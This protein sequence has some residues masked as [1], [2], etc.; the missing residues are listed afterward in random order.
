M[1]ENPITRTATKIIKSTLH[2]ERTSGVPRSVLSRTVDITRTYKY[3]SIERVVHVHNNQPYTHT[4]ILTLTYSIIMEITLDANKRFVLSI[5]FASDGH[6][7][8]SG[9]RTVYSGSTTTVRWSTS[10]SLL[11]ECVYASSANSSWYTFLC[12]AKPLVSNCGNFR[13]QHIFIRRI[14][15]KIQ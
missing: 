2:S 5:T 1:N 14:C 6:Q 7:S 3:I 11:R 12:A 13:F 10:E 15:E 8:H 9:Q 4:P